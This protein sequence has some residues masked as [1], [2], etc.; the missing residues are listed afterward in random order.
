MDR[1][2]DRIRLRLGGTQPKGTQDVVVELR[3]A[4]VGFEVNQGGQAV[5]AWNVKDRRF[6][7]EHLRER[8]VGIGWRMPAALPA[9]CAQLRMLH[10]RPGWRAALNCMQG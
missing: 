3:F 10:S 1:S 6:V 2:S 8:K 4:P 7:F 5:L 9:P